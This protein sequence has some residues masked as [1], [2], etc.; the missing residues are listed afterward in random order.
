MRE[1]LHIQLSLIYGVVFLSGGAMLLA[2]GGICLAGNLSVLKKDTIEKLHKGTY[3]CVNCT[4]LHSQFHITLSYLLGLESHHIHVDRAQKF[5]D[6][7]GKDLTTTWPVDCAVWLITDQ[8]KKKASF[9]KADIDILKQH[10]MH[11]RLLPS[12][13]MYSSSKICYLVSPLWSG[14]HK[15]L[16]SFC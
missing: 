16:K 6:E 5:Q 3:M 10:S 7:K 13:H 9:S 4:V 15:C 14:N 12:I 2:K 8:V 11:V 1:C